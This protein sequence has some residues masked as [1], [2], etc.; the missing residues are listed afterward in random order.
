MFVVVVS[1]SLLVLRAQDFPIRLTDLK[2]KIAN[3][4]SIRHHLMPDLRLIERG[5]LVGNFLIINSSHT[6]IFFYEN[7]VFFLC[8]PLHYFFIFLSNGL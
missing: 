1:S 6:I 3:L 7:D 5:S 8:L 2:K 4:L